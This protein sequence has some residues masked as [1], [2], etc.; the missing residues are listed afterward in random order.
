LWSVT[1]G[2]KAD[3]G[4]VPDLLRTYVYKEPKNDL[5]G[6]REIVRALPLKVGDVRWRV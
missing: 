1:R 3:K 6:L 5:E 4:A 2:S